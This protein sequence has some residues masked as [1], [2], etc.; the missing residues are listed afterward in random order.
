MQTFVFWL[1]QRITK[2]VLSSWAFLQESG[3]GWHSTT[4][5][6]ATG[7]GSDDEFFLLPTNTLPRAECPFPLFPLQLNL[8]W[9][10]RNPFS[11]SQLSIFVAVATPPSPLHIFVHTGGP[12]WLC[13]DMGRG[14]GLQ[15]N[16][17][18]SAV[19]GTASCEEWMSHPWLFYS[20][21]HGG[22]SASW[23]LLFFLQIWGL[24]QESR[25][26]HKADIR[27]HGLLLQQ[28]ICISSLCANLSFA[29]FFRW[30]ISPL[31]ATAS[32][33][34]GMT[35]AQRIPRATF[36]IQRKQKMRAQWHSWWPKYLSFI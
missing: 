33:M 18:Q 29:G 13:G 17:M 8:W 12:L 1:A 27:W 2:N 7:S 22:V 14:L 19:R 32:V 3:R 25:G 35:V 9:W 30:W 34:L 11:E 21:S 4:W 23:L 10:S 16:D 6:P 36:S 31:T 20:I 26:G 15:D 28:Q 5:H 24:L